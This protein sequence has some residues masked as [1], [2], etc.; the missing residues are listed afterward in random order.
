MFDLDNLKQIN[1][2]FGHDW[3]D[4]YIRRTGECFAK[5]APGAYRLRA[6]QQR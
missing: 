3:G 2:T 5:N 6:H 1:D 4:E